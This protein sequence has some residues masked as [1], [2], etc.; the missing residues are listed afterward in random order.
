MYRTPPVTCSPDKSIGLNPEKS[1]LRS[2]LDQ[3]YRASPVKYTRFQPFTSTPPK[4]CALGDHD[5]D[6]YVWGNTELSVKSIKS[7]VCEKVLRITPAPAPTYGVTIDGIH[8]CWLTSRPRGVNAALTLPLRLTS[9][10]SVVCSMGTLLLSTKFRYSDAV[11]ER[12]KSRPATA[13]T[14]GVTWMSRS[15][16]SDGA[17]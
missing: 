11:V 16:P 17:L 12:L 8:A 5:S 7:P 9:R 1:E 4:T 6:E 13:V 3:I 14:R 10:N 15:S 2:A